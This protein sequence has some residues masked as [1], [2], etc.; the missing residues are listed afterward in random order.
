MKLTEK[1]RDL[2]LHKRGLYLHKRGL[3]FNLYFNRYVR[4]KYK[5]L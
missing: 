1:S 3:H 2:H 4:F 5:F